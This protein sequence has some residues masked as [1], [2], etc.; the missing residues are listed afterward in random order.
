MDGGLQHCTGGGDKKK[1][2]KTIPKKKK[3][4][5]KAKWF[6]EEALNSCEKKRSEG[7]RRKGTIYPFECRVPK[8][9]KER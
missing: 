3:D 4:M 9:G 6:S 7:Q 5:E 1:K 8:N 2:K